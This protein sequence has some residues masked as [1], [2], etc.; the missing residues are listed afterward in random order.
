MPVWLF[1]FY[2]DDIVKT[3]LK[4]TTDA[5]LDYEAWADKFMQMIYWGIVQPRLDLRYFFTG[6]F[7]KLSAH[8]LKMNAKKT[9]VIGV[10][11]R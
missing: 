6:L 3:F 10:G 11:Y 2:I 8:N 7:A 4:W 5:N 9:K 1:N